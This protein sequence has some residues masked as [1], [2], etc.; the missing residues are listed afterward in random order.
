[1]ND[2]LDLQ[3][4]GLMNNSTDSHKYCDQSCLNLV[5]FWFW[6]FVLYVI[7]FV[8][9]VHIFAKPSFI[10]KRHVTWFFL[11]YTLVWWA[12]CTVYNVAH[13]FSRNW[14]YLFEDSAVFPE[15]IHN[16][17]LWTLSWKSGGWL[18][19][20]YWSKTYSIPM[21]CTLSMWWDWVVILETVYSLSAQDDSTHGSLVRSTEGLTTHF[22][23]VKS[24][25]S[26]HR[27]FF[28]PVR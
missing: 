28:L 6:R 10:V 8:V 7:I 13:W 22:L 23:Q 1:M 9:H 25:I 20:E 11:M 26:Y 12:T 17:K 5:F 18:T 21:Q 3:T 16:E 27:W 4:F 24:N 15:K 19:T 2:L 14:Y